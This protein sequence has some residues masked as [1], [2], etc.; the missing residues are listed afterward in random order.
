MIPDDKLPVSRSDIFLRSMIGY[1]EDLVIVSHQAKIKSPE[2]RA[3]KSVMRKRLFTMFRNEG[4]N[5][6][7]GMRH[8][9]LRNAAGKDVGDT[10]SSMSSHRD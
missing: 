8:H 6:T 2:C 9:F 3:P 4:E 1:T 7:L 5:R 10:C